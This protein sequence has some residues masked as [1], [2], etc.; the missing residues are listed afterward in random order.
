MR[1]GGGVVYTVSSP[2]K[3]ILNVDDIDV[4]LTLLAM[5]AIAVYVNNHT[6]VECRDAETIG[7]EA[8]KSVKNQRRWG[9]DVIGVQIT[10]LVEH[11]VHKI[12]GDSDSLLPPEEEDE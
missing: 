12:F 6:A 9:V 8:T 10:D 3:T 2:D 1:V 4:S 11:R 7:A 5:A